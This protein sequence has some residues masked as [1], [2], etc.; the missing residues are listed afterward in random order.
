[1]TRP[2]TL[3]VGDLVHVARHRGLF[4]IV[5]PLP[6]GSPPY[7][8]VRR[9][10]L[11]GAGEPERTHAAG[12]TPSADGPRI[13]PTLATSRMHHWESQARQYA[14]L[15]HPGLH[16]ELHTVMGVPIHCLLW[17]GQPPG[18]RD[19]GPRSRLHGILNY[20]P[21]DMPPHQGAGDVNVWVDPATW[22]RGIGS[23]LLREAVR[24]WYVD[25]AAQ[26][27]TPAGARLAESVI[28]RDT[29]K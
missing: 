17:Y 9:V 3:A 12:L 11:A 23:H 2:L 14:R 24:R 15:S 13:A 10:G 5:D 18:T 19:L 25:L 28:R 26:R 6:T 1:M 16:H 7:Y 4:R 27:Y 20:Y 8:Y 22:C 29:Q 21:Y